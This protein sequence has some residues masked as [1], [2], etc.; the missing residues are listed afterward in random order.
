MSNMHIIAKYKDTKIQFKRRVFLPHKSQKNLNIEGDIIVKM[1]DEQ[2]VPACY[3]I[4]IIPNTF[5]IELT[6]MTNKP[7]GTKPRTRKR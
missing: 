4:V 2:R 7:A 5:K 6:R 3:Y 1:T